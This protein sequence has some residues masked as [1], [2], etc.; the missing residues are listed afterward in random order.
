[1]WPAVLGDSLPV[2]CWPRGLRGHRGHGGTARMIRLLEFLPSP[3]AAFLQQQLLG[4]SGGFPAFFAR[5]GDAT[6][7]QHL[8]SAPGRAG[9]ARLPHCSRLET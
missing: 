7:E 8:A 6:K 3:V 2:G 9:E 4:G 1:M 5:R